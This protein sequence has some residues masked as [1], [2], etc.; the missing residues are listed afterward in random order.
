MMHIGDLASHEAKTS[1][2]RLQILIGERK[3]RVDLVK[4]GRASA[5]SLARDA[6]GPAPCSA[7]GFE[8]GLLPLTRQVHH[9]PLPEFINP[10]DDPCEPLFS[11]AM[12]RSRTMSGS[13]NSPIPSRAPTRS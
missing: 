4:V 5:R 8:A 11:T 9:L 10:Q 1:V 6:S 7:A 13:P 12:A 2:P 3:R